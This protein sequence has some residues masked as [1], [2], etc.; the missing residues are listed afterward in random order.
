MKVPAD[1]A[2]GRNTARLTAADY[3]TVSKRFGVSTA[4]TR[5]VVHVE[6]A[7]A[8]FWNSGNL[9]LLY[10]GHIAYRETKN[11]KA[12]QAKL[13]RAGVAWRSWGDKKYGNATTSRNRLTLALS[14]AGAQAF[15]WASYGLP[16]TMGFNAQMMRY[17]SAESMFNSYLDGERN[18]LDGMF[19]FIRG[20]NLLD[21]LKSKDW[22]K[23]ARGYNGSGYASHGYHTRLAAAFAKFE[24]RQEPD[25]M[26]D[27]VLRNGDIGQAVADLQATLNTLFGSDLET[28]GIY[29]RATEQSVW[30]AQGQLGL[31]QDGVAGPVTLAALETAKA[32]PPAAPVEPVNRAPLDDVIDKIAAED[33]M[34]KTQT[35][36]GLGGAAAMIGTIKT[37]ADDASGILGNIAGFVPDWFIPTALI[38]GAGAFAFTWWDRRKYKQMARDAKAV[39]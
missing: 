15:R 16:Q 4:L 12:L 36:S 33:R 25:A 2:Q 17:D 23:F 18:Q 38:I 8:G 10:E 35:M 34:S 26:A 31:T 21:A 9:K 11:D 27:G 32:A 30:Y 7:G 37:I 6:A 20:A 5:A 14:I 1:F 24:S 39:L 29:G 22:H 13:V 28:D 3:Q 19:R